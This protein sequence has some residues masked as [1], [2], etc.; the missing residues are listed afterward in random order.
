MI[1]FENVTKIYP[2]GTKAVDGLNL[3]IRKGE[4]VVLI[5]P[6]GCGKTTTLEMINRLEEPTEGTIYVNGND[7]SKI[8]VV[9]LRRNIG[10][11]IQNIGLLPHFR[12]SSN[13]GLVPSLLKWP[14]QRID[15]RV[16]ELLEMV[17]MDPE[18]YANRY[19][20][21]LSG[22]QQQR[23][24]VLRALAA[25]PEIILMDEPFGALDPVTRENLQDELK[26]LQARLKK[27]IVFVTHDMDEALKLGDR[28]VIM[29]DGKVVQA[30]TPEMLLRKPA[31]DFVRQFIGRERLAVK[32][33]GLTVDD[34]AIKTP[35]TAPPHMGLAQA[36]RLMQRK[37]VDTLMV[38]DDDG[39]FVGIASA[40]E[41]EALK[42]RPDSLAEV[43]QKDVATVMQGSSAKQAFEMLF[44]AKVGVVP[45]IDGAGRLH[46][47][48]TRGSLA[49]M[50]YQA[51]WDSN[52]D[53][54]AA[55][56]SRSNGANGQPPA[57][58][59]P[60]SPAQPPTAPAGPASQ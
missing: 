38:V 26:K 44:I 46:G 20:R 25:E 58:P 14:K 13:I 42:R 9:E 60:L 49:E 56:N 41:I 19:P 43:V 48:V 18:V 8:S 40:R 52:G 35:V 39:K 16:R 5:G 3:H 57:P 10:Y 27:T 7:T 29:K 23:I 30:D 15:A 4:L 21:E 1:V 45:V 37:H 22:G 59:T 34:V 53:G 54:E 47:I 6:S 50:L 11:V 17:G 33:D 12:I 24:G 2:G 36:T 31:D 51:L 28:V 55:G 32:A